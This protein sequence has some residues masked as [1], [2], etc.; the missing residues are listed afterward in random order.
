MGIY[1]RKDSPYFWMSFCVNNKQYQRST[2][3]SDKR[4]AE[5]IYAKVVTQIVEGKWFETDNAKKHTFDEM[6]ERYLAYAKMRRTHRSYVN[7]CIYVKHLTEVFGGLTLDQITPALISQYRDERLKIRSPQTVKHEI[8]CL[9]HAFTV[10]MKEWDWISHNPCLK[11]QKPQV[12][13]EILRWLSS[14]EEDKLINAA[15]GYLNNQLTE[16]I[17][18]A[19][20]TGMRQGEILS[21]KWKDIDMFRK[22]ITIMQHKTKEPKAIPMTDAVFNLLKNKSKTISMS[23]F[24]FTTT[25]GTRIL[26]T[27]LQREFYK[28][29]DKA[30]ITNFRFH[31]LRHTFATRLVQSCV[32]LYTVSKLLGHKDI[33]TT[34]RYAHHNI[35]SVRLAVQKLNNFS[36]KKQATKEGVLC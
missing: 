1:K 10:A 14:E 4:L 28:A 12:N 5:A 32:D 24:V 6:M 27:N 2:Q 15:K 31:D 33:K 25:K 8:N 26:N 19:L 29:V 9:S 35:E 36:D 17:T 21:L 7:T 23:G 13:N 11:V 16:I 34:Q 20:G 22:T 3:T 18:V 30:G